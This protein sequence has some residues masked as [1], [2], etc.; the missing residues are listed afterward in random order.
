[1]STQGPPVGRE[2][3]LA[4]I[5][6][7]ASQA[8]E[9]RAQVVYLEGFAGVGKGTLTRDALADFEDWREIVVVLDQEQSDISGDL[10]RRL[11]LPPGVQPRGQSVDE[12]VAEGLQR[13]QILRRPTVITLI[14]TQWI[15]GESAEALLRIC[16]MLRDAAILVVMSGRPSTRPE[17]NRLS[18][19]ARNSPNGTHIRIAPFGPAE[20]QALLAQY[21]TT[22][23]SAGVVDMVQAE[24]AGYPLLLHE[25][26]RHLAETPIGTRQLKTSVAA[27][28][29]SQAAQWMYRAFEESL[30]PLS[31]ETREV[32]RLLAVAGVPLTE[33][34][35]SQALSVPVELS[36]AVASG[37]V[38]WDQRLLGYKVRNGLIA[39]TLQG[40]MCP[41]ESVGLHRKLIGV[42]DESEDLTH[43]VE[44]AVARPG[45]EPV[46]ELLSDL[47]LDAGDSLARGDLER[48][49]QRFLAAARI[50]PKPQALQEV[51]YFGAILGHL[52]CFVLF[53][54]KFKALP[55]SALRQSALALEALDRGQL[56]DAVA[57]LELHARVDPEDPAA[58]SYAHALA[59]VA[60][61]LGIRGRFG[62]ATLVKQETVRMLEAKER[63]LLERL[64]QE[65]L[66]PQSRA[67]LEWELSHAAGL[68]AFIRLW[69]TFDVQDPG[70]MRTAEADLSREIEQIERVPHSALFVTGLRAVRGS[71]RRHLGDPVGAY[72]D[73]SP[74]MASSVEVSFLAYDKAQL[75]Q[76][77]FMAG[78]WEEAMDVA[79]VA[80]GDALLQG[81]DATSLI[82][83]L[84]WALVPISRG[85]HDDVAPMI[86]EI[87]AVR[88]D[89]GVLVSSTLEYLYAWE[90]VVS[91]DHERAVQHLLR[92]RDEAGGWM[93]A[94]IDA[95]L[96]L[97]RAAHY[98]GLGSMIPALHSVVSTGGCPVSAELEDAVTDYMEAFQAWERHDPTEAMRRLLSVNRWRDSQP[99]LRLAQQSRDAGGFRLFKA[100]TCLDAAALL[101]AYPQEL[102]RHRTPVIEGLE[103]AV[104][105]FTSVGSPGLLQLALGELS[106]LRPRLDRGEP[107]K[108]VPHVQWHSPELS[109]SGAAPVMKP[110]LLRENVAHERSGP[111]DGLSGR[112]RQVAVLIADGWTNKEI[113]EEL[114]VS[115]R[116]IDFHV[117][118]ALTKFDV[119]SRHE[120]R[121]RLRDGISGG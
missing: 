2:Q 103:W 118:N 67:A 32:L 69:Q 52:D 113:A 84:T 40:L 20:T 22:P 35:I 3:E 5:R 94:G 13:A 101:S 98:A 120:I 58:L 30:V 4:L 44:I 71:R 39:E 18:A 110:E 82:A 57:A 43:R 111:L 64:A 115:V 56:R 106:A 96:L 61:Q 12:L 10:L 95:V 55:P 33:H 26:G 88:K 85:R 54:S 48:A 89:A 9:R 87:A 100:F 81:E 107:L 105:L 79:A 28:K 91:A 114:G 38:V 74:T 31:D 49:F 17:V 99:P 75:A 62:R 7:A 47:R 11:V 77:L 76:V 78:L 41:E 21:L 73:L 25:V 59:L 23:L 14:N 15:D 116:T 24:T 86:A 70:M 97:V 53:E 90:A 68:A 119:S 29:A 80:A 93:N 60:G 42:V 112:E 19:F 37:L 8:A 108:R 34:Q 46:E 6:Q 121:H 36:G 63:S 104:A 50:A 27:M 65:E 66:T 102:K 72:E 16:T 109:S 45:T 92:L 117:R 51:V 83:Y 1:M